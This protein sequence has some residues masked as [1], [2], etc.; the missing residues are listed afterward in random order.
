VKEYRTL[1]REGMVVR[2][3]DGDKLGKVK[4]IRG[5]EFIIEKGLLFKEDYAARLDNIVDVQGDEITYEKAALDAEGRPLAGA[6]SG[7]P[8]ERESEVRMPLAEE[9]LVVEKQAKQAGE[10]KIHKEVVAETRQV[11]VPVQREE[12][13]VERVPV[14]EAATGEAFSERDIAVPVMEEEVRVTKQPV[15]R[16]E[17]RVSKQPMQEQRTASAEVRREEAHVD[18]SEVRRERRGDIEVEDAEV[19]RAPTRDDD[20][21]KS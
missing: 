17:V 4:S 5:D 1:I 3:T 19:R 14:N 11:T 9:Q 13:V 18:D 21:K 7:A 10:V 16:E 15:V 6:A 12:V 20:L 8:K 2:A